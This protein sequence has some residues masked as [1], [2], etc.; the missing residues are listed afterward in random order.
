MKRTVDLFKLIRCYILPDQQL[1]GNVGFL[2][3]AS[4]RKPIAKPGDALQ[5]DAHFFIQVFPGPAGI[6]STHTI[7]QGNLYIRF[8]AIA[9][10]IFKK[11]H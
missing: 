7:G 9:D 3:C 11:K 4:G 1:R 5:L 10:F 2:R 8:H 6:V